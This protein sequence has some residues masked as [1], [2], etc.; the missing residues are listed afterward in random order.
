[1]RALRSR[2]L[3][4]ALLAAAL[5]LAYR[6][7][8]TGRL[9]ADRDVFRIFFPDSAF[10]IECLSRGDLPLWQPYAFLGQPFAASLQA[11]VFYPPRVLA[12]LLAGPYWSITVLQVLHAALAAV[13][14]FLLVRGGLGRSRPAALLAAAAFALSPML[15][16]LATTPNL[17]HAAAWAPWV[18]GAALRG[19]ARA[20]AGFLALG[21]LAGA[22][23]MV[24][25]QL[26]LVAMVALRRRRWRGVAAG[27]P[28]AFAL[29]AVALL[30]AAELAL[31][32][33]RR[34]GRADPLDWSASPVQ[35]L[36]LGWPLADSP[37]GPYWGPDQWLILQ[38]FLGTGVVALALFG[39][40]RGGRAR[41]FAVA[42]VVFLALA[43]GRHFPPAGWLLSLPPLGWFRYPAKYLVGAAFC[44]AVLSAFGVDRLS[45]VARRR[46]VR[47][48]WAGAVV[49]GALVLLPV[50]ALLPTGWPWVVLALAVLAAVGMVVPPRLAGTAAA[51]VCLA[52]LSLF[53]AL[54]VG[55]GWAPAAAVARPAAVRS[56]VDLSAGRVSVEV[57]RRAREAEGR[58][59]LSR[60]TSDG[61]LASRDLLVPNRFAEDRIRALEGYGAPEPERLFQFHLAGHRAVHDLAGVRHFIRA[62]GP[63]H[64]D[65]PSVGALPGGAMLYQS[66]TAFPRAW[67]VP[68][69]RV[70]PDEEVLAALAGD[71]RPFRE[72]ALLAGGE[73][74]SGE[75][76][77][78][79][80]AR[81]IGEGCRSV[82][83]EATAC[84]EAYLVLA[85]SFAPGWRAEVDGERREVHRA[86]LALRAVRVDAGTH[87]VRMTYSPTLLW[88]GLGTSMA[89]LLALIGAAARRSN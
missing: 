11:Q 61:L 47:A 74:L 19:R 80:G 22:P 14:T 27:V 35:L 34:T 52:E 64:R 6:P 25:W 41:P 78:A 5:A 54:Q 76:C 82:E 79:A 30:P 23:E 57:G 63:P 13:G 58:V 38:L 71:S 56:M 16:D 88:M 24:L 15:T 45:A 4:A 44:L 49:A 51:G 39:A 67:V 9:V 86:D 18:A 43:L 8:F 3:L 20:L 83:L 77:P 10:L 12:V 87:R 33:A 40:R 48:R 75:A 55:L 50:G 60:E 36:A 29:A 89:A 66:D 17:V 21:L 28:W 26:A 1:V 69:A 2:A 53:H 32:S 42:A 31:E 68:T 84:G 81:V 62:G 72:V 7:I 65:T 85:D 46:R 59:V 37:R 70:S 73:P